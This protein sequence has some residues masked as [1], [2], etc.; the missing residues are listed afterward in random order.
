MSEN[1]SDMKKE[2][3]ALKTEVVRTSS[4]ASRW[5]LST[6]ESL[7]LGSDT[8]GERPSGGRDIEET[9]GGMTAGEWE[10]VMLGERMIE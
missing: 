6:E 2:E 10:Q 3:R 7:E 4:M 8:V 9:R 5:S 1:F